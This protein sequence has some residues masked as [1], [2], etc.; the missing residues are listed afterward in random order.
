MAEGM[1]QAIGPRSLNGTVKGPFE[2]ITPPGFQ[3]GL[4]LADDQGHAA[5]IYWQKGY[6]VILIGLSH[7]KRAHGLALKRRSQFGPYERVGYCMWTN[8][9]QTV[10]FF[11][12]HGSSQ[13]LTI[14]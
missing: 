9:P 7:E 12:R 11:K 1:V 8:W 4:L 10:E 3:H 5:G 13:T 6:L 14:V 2:K